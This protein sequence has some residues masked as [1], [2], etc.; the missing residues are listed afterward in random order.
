[1]KSD[2]QRLRLAVGRALDQL[3]QG[4]H[5]LSMASS[6]MMIAGATTADGGRENQYRTLSRKIRAVMEQYVDPL[7]E[8]VKQL[9][10]EEQEQEHGIEESNR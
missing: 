9:Q 3:D 8:Q 7:M 2:S 10:G 5:H 6:D 4:M 1:M